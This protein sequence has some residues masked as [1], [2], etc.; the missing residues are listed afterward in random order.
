MRSRPST[1]SAAV[2]LASLSSGWCLCGS[3]ARLN[4][5]N[6]RIPWGPPGHLSRTARL[7]RPPAAEAR[8]AP[9]S[10]PTLE[11]ARPEGPLSLTIRH[12]T[13]LALEN[14]R[15]LVVERFNPQIQ[16]TLVQDQLAAFDPDLTAQIS[17]ERDKVTAGP[18]PYTLDGTSVT[19]GA[20]GSL[21]TGTTLGLTAQTAPVLTPG[22]DE[23]VY[24][25]RVAFSATQSLLRGFGP[26]VNL[27]SVRQA[28]MDVKISQY[29]LRGVVQTLVAQ[30]EETYWDYILSERQMAIVNQ[31]L[32]LAQRQLQETQERIRLGDL[33]PSEQPAAEAE[34]A[35]R[36]EDLINARSTLA[37]TKLS[38]LR[39]INPPGENPWARDLVLE[40][41]PVMA[42]VTLDDVASHVAL[43]LQMRPDLNQARLLW[44]RDDL[45]VVKT[46]N[47]LLPRLDLFVTLGK[48]GY[49]DSF[50]GSLGHIGGDTYDALV[51]LAFEVPPLRAEPRRV[52]VARS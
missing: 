26:A 41:P 25:S 1:L 33:A 40:S 34:V 50:G 16:R 31:S 51:G 20:Q 45:E 43:A 37:K 2:L 52:S 29:E 47:G 8:P 28:R 44:Q 18:A 9:G 19:V 32:E 48:T 27:A 5:Q 10:P 30:V 35:L 23:E 46:R 24:A 6:R 17:Q 21:P 3:C 39:L 36:Q 22:E 14:N 38:L 7:R 15:S 49:A 12:A 42:S 11:G 4:T 13:W